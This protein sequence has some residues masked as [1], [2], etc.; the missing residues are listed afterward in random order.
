MTFRLE[1]PQL[2]RLNALLG[3]HFKDAELLKKALAH[4]SVSHN[5]N[6]RLEF[7]GDALLNFIIGAQL[8]YKFPTAQEGELTRMR[9]RLVREETVAL[10]ARE[11]QL[12]DFIQLGVGELKSGGHNRASILA[13]ALEAII[14]AIYLDASLE[15]CKQT[16]LKWYDTQLKMIHPDTIQKDPK[17]LL[18]EYLQAKSLATPEYVVEKISGLAH[19]QT[20]FVSCTIKA[21]SQIFKGQGR[22][23]RVA[24][25]AAAQIALEA[26]QK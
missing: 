1:N 22:S 3:Y 8:F 2:K 7:L 10:I 23:R 21:L 20:F 24:E 15:V 4:R 16:L 11:L 6:E 25:Q 26:L 18:Q 9:A 5:N 17:T 19:E 14:G 13:D 12:H